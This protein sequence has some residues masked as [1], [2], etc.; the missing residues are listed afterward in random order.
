M[1]FRSGITTYTFASITFARK[2]DSEDHEPWFYADPVLTKD[3]VLG[4]TQVYL[5]KGALV[6]PP[7]SFRASCLTG[8]DRIALIGA[9]WTTATLTNSRSHTDTATLVKAR[10]INSGDNSHWFIDLSFELRP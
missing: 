1:S 10:P 8:A 5:D 3:P 6:A 2:L 9:L 4:G 7:L